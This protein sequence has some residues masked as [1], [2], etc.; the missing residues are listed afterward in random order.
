M[1]G[2]LIGNAVHSQIL[3]SPLSFGPIYRQSKL[4]KK[5][6]TN[7]GLQ[8]EE[9]DLSSA[10]EAPQTAFQK[11]LAEIWQ[12]GL[13]IDRVGINDNF[14]QLGG[15]SLLLTQLASRMKK[16]LNVNPKVSLL[17]ESPTIAAWSNISQEKGETAAV[18]KS[19]PIKRV[20]RDSYRA[21]KS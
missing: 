5:P 13:G 1:L 18:E 6:V 14:F 2:D 19:S 17:F 20:S 16:E 7:E 12:K 9:N 4:V 21:T 15:H 8:T 3:V 10:Y 11:T